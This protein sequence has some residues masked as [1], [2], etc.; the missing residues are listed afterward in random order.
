MLCII[1]LGEYKIY[2]RFMVTE[3]LNVN[4]RIETENLFE[5]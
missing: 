4:T 3:V 2:C 1:L 5:F